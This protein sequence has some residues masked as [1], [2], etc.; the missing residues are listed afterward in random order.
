MRRADPGEPGVGKTRLATELALVAHSAGAVALYGRC[1]EESLVPHQPFVEALRH[2]VASCPIAQLTGQLGSN[3]GELRRLVPELAGRVQTLADPLPGDPE[4]ARYRLFEA[5]VGLLVAAA[6]ARPVVLVLDDLHWADRPTM[7][8]LTHLLRHSRGA[9]L[10]VIGTYRDSELEPGHP[11]SETLA[12]LSRE[13]RLERHSLA[14]LDEDA[15]ASLVRGH[16]GQEAPEL[17]KTIFTDTDGN[18]FFVVEM[19]RHLAESTPGERSVPEGVKDVIGCWW[20]Y[21]RR[22]LADKRGGEGQQQVELAD[23][24]A[25][26]PHQSDELL[27]LDEALD[28]LEHLD[29]RQARIVEM[30]Y[31]AGNPVAEIAEFAGISERTVKRELQTARLFLKHQLRSAD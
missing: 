21:A 1:D 16:T 25:L 12:L 13:Q 17:A 23:D 10:L 14:P 2:Y 19:L 5:V 9:R 4:G 27:G 29:A 6:R 3:G 28:R 20:I 31:F 8:L 11:L 30:H 24:I 26:T 15:V 7:L 18:P 22:R